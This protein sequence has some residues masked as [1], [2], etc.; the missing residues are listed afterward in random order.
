MRTFH[1]CFGDRVS[2]WLA[3][4]LLAGCGA[5]TVS[6]TF[7]TMD[8]L[9]RPD[10][11]LVHDFE[12]TPNELES[13]SGLGPRGSGGAGAEPQTKEEIEVGRSFVTALTASLIAELQ[14]RGIKAE[15]ANQSSEPGR[16][17]AS[18]RGRFLRASQRDGNSLAGFDLGVSPMRARILI[19]QGTGLNSQL[20]S[21]A[22]IAIPSNLKPNLGALLASTIDSEAKLMAVQ[23]ADRFADYYKRQGW[24]K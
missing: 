1:H 19:F 12:V 5:A 3:A 17:T 9:S 8:G 18:L 14:N 24:I 20:V 2:V 10:H 23:I 13:K 16:D 21:E 4:L 15:R 11:V 6:S 7:P 22:E